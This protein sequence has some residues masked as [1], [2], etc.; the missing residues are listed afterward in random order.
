MKK[1]T[2]SSLT[3]G[4]LVILCLATNNNKTINPQ[5][6]EISSSEPNSKN[7]VNYLSVAKLNTF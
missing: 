2:I 7:T 6:D 1:I 4:L 5:L 3:I